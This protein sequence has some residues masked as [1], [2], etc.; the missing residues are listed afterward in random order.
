MPTQGLLNSYARILP[1]RRPTQG[2]TRPTQ[3]QLRDWVTIS[4]PQSQQE[5]GIKQWTL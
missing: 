1:C 2:L 3:G 5:G 4:R